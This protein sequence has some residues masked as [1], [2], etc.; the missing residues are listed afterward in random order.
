MKKILAIMMT[1]AMLA[2][3]VACQNGI[4]EEAFSLEDK[5]RWFN[6]VSDWI[7]WSEQYASHLDDG[8][9]GVIDYESFGFDSEEDFIVDYMV[10]AWVLRTDIEYTRF[11][12]GQ[13]GKPTGFAEL[14]AMGLIFRDALD[15]MGTPQFTEAKNRLPNGH[16][17]LMA[18]VSYS[19]YSRKYGNSIMLISVDKEHQ[20]Q[21]IWRG[22]FQEDGKSDEIAE[23]VVLDL[24]N[25]VKGEF[26]R[27][28]NGEFDWV[29][30]YDF[31]H[32]YGD[33]VSPELRVADDAV[34]VLDGQEYDADGVLE[35]FESLEFSS[36]FNGS[37][38]A[39]S[40]ADDDIVVTGVRF[41]R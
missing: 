4:S 2:T 34:F 36:V 11:K 14:E 17:T 1:V 30:E 38:I 18:S 3:L 33:I 16:Y 27:F 26:V 39:F 19:A 8:V 23:F 32:E 5:G 15:A 10:R 20:E 41:G 12:L 29:Y 28:E 24:P 25:Y 31:D 9:E 40:I 6:S 7:D 35:A 22:N 21:T 37:E 13:D